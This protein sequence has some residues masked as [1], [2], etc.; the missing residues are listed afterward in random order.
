MPSS[1]GSLV[2][3]L[4]R[5]GVPKGI[6]G[7]HLS[8]GTFTQAIL[9]L[10]RILDSLALF[11]Q[12]S[13]ETKSRTTPLQHSSW[14]LHV[15]ER[16]WAAIVESVPGSLAKSVEATSRVISHFLESIQ[17]FCNPKQRHLNLRHSDT[18]KVRVWLTCLADALSLDDMHQLPSIRP[19]LDRS[20]QSLIEYTPKAVEFAEIVED[21]ILGRIV[22]LQ[23]KQ[24]DPSAGETFLRVR[25]P[26]V[27][28]YG[29]SR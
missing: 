1:T 7:R 4:G 22:T 5:L 16:L 6:L 18:E 21:E 28:I 14:I 8:L 20:F 15:Y 9:S 25:Q 12:V 23:K 19:A 24:S 11:S 27:S 13:P 10:L 3:E 26:F 17:K 2:A 29:W